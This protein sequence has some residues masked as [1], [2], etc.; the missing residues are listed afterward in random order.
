MRICFNFHTMMKLAL[1]IPVAFKPKFRSLPDVSKIY[2]EKR[3]TLNKAIIYCQFE[4]VLLKF[5][6]SFPYP[7]IVFEE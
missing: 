2:L 3:I 4:A 5:S 1:S 7:S 6:Y